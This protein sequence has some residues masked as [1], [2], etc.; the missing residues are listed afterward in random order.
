[1]TDRRQERAALARYIIWKRRMQ[2]VAQLL[3]RARRQYILGR[4]HGKEPTSS[5]SGCSYSATQLL[6]RLF[7]V[8]IEGGKTELLDKVLER[9][10]TTERTTLALKS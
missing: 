9:L 2:A 7:T 3:R 10:D 5:T 6:L 8:D 1:M 4:I